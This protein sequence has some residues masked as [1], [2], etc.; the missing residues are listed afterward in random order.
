MMQAN[1][2]QK[3]I[4]VQEAG[5]QVLKKEA[6]TGVFTEVKKPQVLTPVP[7]AAEPTVAPPAPATTPAVSTATSTATAK[8]TK[9][10]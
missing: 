1:P 5:P 9:V 8:D 4:I 7:K 6:P 2:D 10:N 3:P